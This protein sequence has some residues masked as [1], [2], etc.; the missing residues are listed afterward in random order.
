MGVLLVQ[1]WAAVRVGGDAGGRLRGW[2][3]GQDEGEGSRSGLGSGAQAWLAPHAEL[4]ALL[5]ILGVWS[6]VFE[7]PSF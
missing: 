4:T 6:G 2:A 1:P 3:A 5:E 7:R